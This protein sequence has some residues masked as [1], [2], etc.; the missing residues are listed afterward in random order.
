MEQYRPQTFKVCKLIHTLDI[1]NK[2]D[3]FQY[4][5]VNQKRLNLL[6]TIYATWSHQS[7]AIERCSTK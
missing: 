1:A 3:G 7:N 2:N 5:Y 6:G 4:L